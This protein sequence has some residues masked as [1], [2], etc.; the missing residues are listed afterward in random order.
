MNNVDRRRVWQ[1][2]ITL[3]LAPGLLAGAGRASEQVRLIA[4]PRTP[5]RYRREVSRNL[6]DGAR[7]VARRE[8][9]ISFAG[10]PE[11]FIVDGAQ[12]AVEFVAPESLASFAALEKA[13]AP[14]I[15]P[16]AL[17]SFGQIKGVPTHGS[18]DLMVDQAISE[19]NT[20]LSAAPLPEEER[21][22]LRHFFATI[23]R[24]SEAITS[25][26]PVD[27]FAPRE[28]QNIVERHLKLPDGGIGKF[29]TRF[30]SQRDEAT[31]LM[32]EAA[33]DIITTIGSEQRVTSEKWS[34]TA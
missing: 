1:A 14:K 23:H 19:A 27:L 13:R 7:L 22:E 3:A 4:P 11:G 8:F 34:L 28:E 16:I 12:T 21:V 9:A 6:V 29:T 30:S 18:L 20:A 15:F 32:R 26:M 24:A 5:M 31:G 2:A 17:D 10:H 33:R 25:E